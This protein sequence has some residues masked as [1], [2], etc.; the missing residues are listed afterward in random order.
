LV[1]PQ[2]RPHAPTA[3]SCLTAP[4]RTASRLSGSV[5]IAGSTTGS[6][7]T[8]T[9]SGR[10]AIRN[11]SL[12]SLPVAMRVLQLTQLMLPG[13]GTISASDAEFTIRGNT[14]EV[15]RCELAAGTIQL[16][17]KGT[18]DIPTFG[19]G[20]RL[21]PR[22]TLPIV[23]DVI[24][25]VTNQIF[26]IDLSG[27]LSEPKASVAA[28]PGITEMPTPP[29]QGTT[30]PAQGTTPPAP[31]DAPPLPTGAQTPAAAPGSPPTPSGGTPTPSGGTPTPPGGT[32]TPPPGTAASAS[33]ATK[34]AARAGELPK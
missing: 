34:P 5:R 3:S 12:A 29:A 19:I 4:W 22:G 6:V 15:T 30:P 26:A 24:G 13:S 18:M 14:A 31:T 33:T 16:S 8:R 7:D 28:L 21:F 10:V 27:T 23:S 32:P 1:C 20:I 25:G 11:A 2:R 9:G 17:G